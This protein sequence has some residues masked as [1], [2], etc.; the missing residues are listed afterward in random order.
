MREARRTYKC[1]LA[2]AIRRLADGVH[3]LT[4]LPVDLFRRIADRA[5]RA[6]AAE[7]SATAVRRV[8]VVECYTSEQD[9]RAQRHTSLEAATSQERGAKRDSIRSLS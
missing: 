5:A 2:D 7:P 8:D 3:D 9:S 4:D 1:V 6:A